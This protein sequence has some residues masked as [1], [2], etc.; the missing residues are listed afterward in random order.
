MTLRDA[1]IDGSCTGLI[2]EASG[3]LS[4]ARLHNTTKSCLEDGRTH[5]TTLHLWIHYHWVGG[6]NDLLFKI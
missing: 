4:Q 1:V 5:K 3:F 6:P 2:I